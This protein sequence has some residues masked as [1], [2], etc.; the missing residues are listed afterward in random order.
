MDKFSTKLIRLAAVVLFGVSLLS[1]SSDYEYSYLYR[2]LPFEMEKV[3]RPQIPPRTVNIADF[4]GVGNGVTL[5]TACFAEAIDVLA[6]NGGGRIVVPGGIWRTGPIMLKDSIELH[7]MK[8]AVLLS[9][10]D[11]SGKA[12]INIVAASNVAVTGDGLIDGNAHG[13]SSQGVQLVSIE[14]SRIV[15]LADC[16]FRNASGTTLS[17]VRSEGLI[18]SDIEIKSSDETGDDGLTL[19]SCRNVLLLDSS[20]DVLADAV[21][22]RSAENVVV[23]NCNLM[24]SS[25][26]FV[27]DGDVNGAIRNVS[28]CGSRV[29]SSDYGLKLVCARGTGALVDGLYV[30]DIVMMNIARDPLFFDL[31]NKTKAG[32]DIDY[33]PADG[34]TPTFRNIHISNVVCSDATRAMYFGGVP[35]KNIENV[36]IKDC[37]IVSGKGADL[38]YSSGVVLDNLALS[39]KDSLA[40]S[41]AN[42]RNVQMHGCTDSHGGAV[43]VVY[44][45]NS[46]NVVI[47]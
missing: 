35:E 15:M 47:D 29:L 5:N 43:P 34:T 7:L 19:D 40:Y 21:C 32:M 28:I 27:V 26:G 20:I 41:L 31:Y 22:F 3:H 30:N 46:E 2:E 44:Q 8:D 39:Q 38:R 45:H 4:G 33:V 16:V 13:W 14:D 18:F 25:G 9:C 10:D 42:C 24:H 1:C 36:E 12:M 23:D 17:S 37:S 6:Q 11:Q